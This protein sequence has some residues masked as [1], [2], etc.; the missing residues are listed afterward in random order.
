MK[1]KQN[2]YIEITEENREDFSAVLPDLLLDNMGISVGAVNSKDEVCGAISLSFDGAR[3]DIDWIYVTPDMRKKGVGRGLMTEAKRIVDHVGI[4]PIYAQ[5]DPL[6]GS[7]L[8]EFFLSLNSGQM[9]VDITYSHDRYMVDA[10]DFLHS[11]HLKMKKDPEYMA[12]PLWEMEE[13]KI[14]A[15]LGIVLENY[16][17]RNPKAFRESCEK[18]LC[19]AVQNGDRIQGIMIM[20]KLPGGDLLLSYIYSRDPRAAASLLMAASLEIK[21]NYKQKRIY[22]DVVSREAE[23]MAKKFFPDARPMHI[24]EADL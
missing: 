1:V 19:F 14:D 6:D 21:R 13:E 20:Q 23:L 3:Y 11:E 2:S 5:F 17:I 16:S 12:E 4:C 24:Y 8:Y 9:I 18:K 7:G 10:L 15:V 22:F